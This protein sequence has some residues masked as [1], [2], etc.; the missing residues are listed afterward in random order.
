[1][2]PRGLL[3]KTGNS[4]KIVDSEGFERRAVDKKA[5]FMGC[6]GGKG[7]GSGAGVS[8]FHETWI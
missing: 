4:K 7:E 3:G 1:V 5:N 2:G 6:L 8:W